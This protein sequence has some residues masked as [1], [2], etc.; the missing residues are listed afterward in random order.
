[1]V[2]VPPNIVEIVIHNQNPEGYQKTAS[3]VH[4]FT[5]HTVPPEYFTHR[6]QSPYSIP[7]ERA[8]SIQAIAR[9]LTAILLG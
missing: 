7:Y 9:E 8:V 2:W 5:K 6:A 3:G 1:M 4:L